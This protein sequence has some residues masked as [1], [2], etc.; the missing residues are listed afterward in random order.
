VTDDAY[1]RGHRA[2]GIDQRL[3]E[4]DRHFNKINGS[5]QTVADRLHE[6]TL[7]VQGLRAQAEADAR[8]RVATAAALKDADDA[9]RRASEQ[10]WSPW[11]KAFAVLAAL[12][13]AVG[14][15][16]AFR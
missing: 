2:G 6:L 13:S 16:F 8:T 12:A 1:E 15:Y 10:T 3:D 5:M 9:R 14:L 4:H 7:A 11:T